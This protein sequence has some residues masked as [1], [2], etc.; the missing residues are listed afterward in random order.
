MTPQGNPP[1]FSGVGAGS[2]AG[3]VGVVAFMSVALGAVAFM[4][5]ATGA[6]AFVSVVAVLLASCARAGL[7][8]A[9]AA[10]RIN[11]MVIR[12]AL[13]PVFMPFWTEF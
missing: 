7:D 12:I 13:L 2:V 8:A 4:S 3:S 1:F 11:G 9:T 5:V 6:V 10:A